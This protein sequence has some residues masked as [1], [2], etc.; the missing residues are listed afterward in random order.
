MYVGDSFNVVEI[1]GEVEYGQ[2]MDLDRTLVRLWESHAVPTRLCSGE[3]T[4]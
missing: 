4:R 2:W 3:V 1:V